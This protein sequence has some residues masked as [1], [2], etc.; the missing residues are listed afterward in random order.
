M[1]DTPA[2][3]LV[4]DARAAFET[5]VRAA[6]PTTLVEQPSTRR[7][8]KEARRAQRVCVATVGKAAAPWGRWWIRQ[9]VADAGLVVTPEGYGARPEHDLPAGWQW[10]EAGHPHPT[11]RSAHAGR[12]LLELASSCTRGDLLIIGLSGGG[13]ACTA[14]PPD[15]IAMDAVRTLNALLLRSG[16]P[17]GAVN[18]V[19]KHVLQG[20]GGRLAAAAAPAR[21]HCQAISDVPGDDLATIASGP[22]VGD[23]TTYEDAR[24]VLRDAGVW[25]SVPA[26][27]RNY[28]QEG[29]RGQHPETVP[30]GDPRL[31]AVRTTVI[32][33]NNTARHSAASHLRNAGYAVRVPDV[34]IEGN[35]PAVGRRHAQTLIHANEPGAWVWGGESTVHVTGEGTGGRNQEAALAA[36]R[37]L[38][39]CTGPAVLW[40]AGT[41]GI[42]GPTDAAGAW[43]TPQTYPAAQ[44]Q[45]CTPASYLADND[46]YS[47]FD[48]V[49][50]LYRPGPTGTNVMDLHIGLVEP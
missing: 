49:G 22:T 23:P 42:D 12:L 15:G 2:C 35:A 45:A 14:C 24:S 48:R 31:H 7:L 50:G 36:V 3:N 20:G 5:G 33:S 34:Q 41:D 39:A 4:S 16:Q 6:H 29:V 21:V 28:L 19:R 8:L 18:A 30:P 32:A 27:I 47:F 9:A 17:I 46:S 43:V 44:A 40:C 10:V 1:A 37:P 26:S 11:E 25:A 13:S 38:A